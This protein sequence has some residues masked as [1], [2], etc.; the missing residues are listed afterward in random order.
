[1]SDEEVEPLALQLDPHQKLCQAVVAKMIPVFPL[2]LQRVQ[3][4][5]IKL[6]HS[7][8]VMPDFKAVIV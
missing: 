4:I 2:H 1:M 7:Y 3:N 5:D 6:L 8:T